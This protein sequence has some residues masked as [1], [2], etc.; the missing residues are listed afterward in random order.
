MTDER[1]R[2]DAKYGRILAQHNRMRRSAWTAHRLHGI[3]NALDVV[4]ARIDALDN[5]RIAA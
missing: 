4:K 1:A 3:S 5:V 2:L